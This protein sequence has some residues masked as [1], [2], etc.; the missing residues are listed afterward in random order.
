MAQVTVKG[1]LK[2][3]LNKPFYIA[4]ERIDGTVELDLRTSASRA[5]L[6]LRW[7]GYE[8]TLIEEYVLESDGGRKL[9]KLKDEKTFFKQETV[10]YDMGTVVMQPGHYS[11][12]FTYQT[13]PNLPGVFFNEHKELGGGMVKSAII[14]KVKVYLDVP[15]KDLKKT[16]KICISEALCRTPQPLHEHKEKGFMLSKGKLKMDYWLPKNV[17]CPGEPVQVRIQVDN[18]SSKKVNHIKV[19]LMRDLSVTAGGISRSFSDVL[20]G[21]EW[22]GVG[23]KSKLENTYNFM[24]KP[25]VFPSTNGHLVKCHYHLD[26]ECDV[27]MAVDLEHHVPIVIVL[28]PAMGVPI[29]LYASY[30]PHGW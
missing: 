19:K 7:K 3:L 11:Y 17:F 15:G 21:E 18:E 30:T 1:N 12:P 22:P 20:Y 29:N 2:L 25:D 14:Y 24:I 16:E 13:P 10:L 4:G 8:R 6:K 26:M 28:M 27:P 9:K 5:Q 23:E